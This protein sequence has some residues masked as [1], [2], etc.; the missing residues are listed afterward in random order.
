MKKETLSKIV[1]AAILIMLLPLFMA[2]VFGQQST[3]KAK[4]LHDFA[5][6]QKQDTIEMLEH[7]FKSHSNCE[8]K[9]VM[10]ILR[11]MVFSVS[12]VDHGGI[13][14]WTFPDEQEEYSENNP[15]RIFLWSEY[16]WHPR[17]FDVVAIHEAFHLT[18]NKKGKYTCGPDRVKTL[19][20]VCMLFGVKVYFTKE[21]NAVITYHL[22]SYRAWDYVE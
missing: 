6:K 22:E 16:N 4:K 3:T 11:L 13:V 9:V 5:R 20:P 21:I 19:A 15:P 1:L 17:D 8:I 7:H 2:V 12:D 10:P 14:A 18:K